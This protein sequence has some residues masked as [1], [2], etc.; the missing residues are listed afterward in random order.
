MELADQIRHLGDRL[1]A[2][3]Q[4]GLSYAVDKPYDADRYERALAIA[5]ELFALADTRPAEE[6]RRTVFEQLTHLTPL[7]GAEAAI[8]D[9]SSQLLLIRRA[10]DGR[11]A[12]PGGLVD[13]GETAAEA[14]VRE[15]REESGTVAEP[16]ALVGL[17]DS[18]RC[19]SEIPL[20]MYHAVVGCRLVETSG[21]PETPWEVIDQSW[22]ADAAGL[23]LSA[24]H[25]PK[26]TDAFAWRR[27]RLAA[28]LDLT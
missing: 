24:G 11:W 21:V 22:F 16:L 3:A 28:H 5:A 25:A 17:Y 7:V 15:A 27:G 20:Q 13:P 23:E 1:R 19:G 2:I 9:E 6:I 26:V 18:R 4:M 12:L 14:A 8:F 10:D